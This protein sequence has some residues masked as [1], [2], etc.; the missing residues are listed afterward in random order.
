VTRLVLISLLAALPAQA[1][2]KPHTEA[3]TFDPRPS[4]LT[5]TDDFAVHAL[6]YRANGS[7]LAVAGDGGRITLWDLKQRAPV[8]TLGG[9]TDAVHAVAWSK[10]GTGSSAAARTGR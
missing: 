6:A 1:Q 4:A 9:H 2:P 5:A 7:L 3:F 8:R 10:D